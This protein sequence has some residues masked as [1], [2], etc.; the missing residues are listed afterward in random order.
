M[1]GCCGPCENSRV[2][3]VSIWHLYCHLGVVVCVRVKFVPV[4]VPPKSRIHLETKSFPGRQSMEDSAIVE[5]LIKYSK[6]IQ[7][8]SADCGNWTKKWPTPQHSIRQQRRVLIQS[9]ENASMWNRRKNKNW[10][11][12]FPTKKHDAKRSPNNKTSL[13]LPTAYYIYINALI[14][15]MLIKKCSILKAVNCMHRKLQT[16]W[17]IQILYCE[18]NAYSIKAEN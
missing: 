14:D 8:S 17:N 11:S 3:S 7:S 18:Y 10:F 4:P 5:G 15:Q 1:S 16:K 6:W 13:S 2:Y 9:F 12:R